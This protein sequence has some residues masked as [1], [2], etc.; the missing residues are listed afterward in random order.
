MIKYFTK[1]LQLKEHYII[2]TDP[3]MLRDVVVWTVKM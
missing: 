3:N 2:N 1:V